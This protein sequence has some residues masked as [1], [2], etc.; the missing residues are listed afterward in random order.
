MKEFV[1]SEIQD[2]KTIQDEYL[3]A[4]VIRLLEFMKTCRI[5][6]TTRIQT[7]CSLAQELSYR[8]GTPNAIVHL[9]ELDRF[10]FELIKDMIKGT[11]EDRKQYFSRLN[12]IIFQM[13][14]KQTYT[15]LENF[16]NEIF[17]LHVFESS[18][19]EELIEFEVDIGNNTYYPN[20]K[21][22]KK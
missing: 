17:G 3:A 5:N 8:G 1:H 15:S 14:K 16:K 9:V 18:G 20:S 11:I 10:H 12:H 19:I 22:L 13:P 7:P 6:C 4:I 21:G 2:G